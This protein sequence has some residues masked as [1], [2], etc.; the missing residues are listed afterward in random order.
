MSKYK[1]KYKMNIRLHLLAV[2]YT[3]TRDEYSH[4]AFT[5]KVQRFSP[6]MRSRGFEVYHYGVETAQSGA[7]VDIEVL[8]LHEWTELRID[9]MMFLN[10]QMSRIEATNRLNDPT[11]LNNVIFNWD[12]PLCKTFNNR[13][14]EK[15][16]NNYR[17]TGTDIVCI[18][19]A[20][21]HNIAIKD[22]N[23]VVVEY[24]IGYAGS[25]KNFRVFESNGW[26]SR[27][28]G[29]ENKNPQNYWFICSNFYNID[30][31]KFNAN[32]TPNRVGF[33]GRI[34]DVKG[35][36]IIVEIA[37]RF[38]HVQF[39]L[40][41]Q[42]DPSK[43]LCEKNI[44]YQPPIHG[45]QRSEYLASLIAVIA[46]SKFLEPFC[47]VAVEA[48]LCGTPVIA[49]D[50]GGFI[51]NIEQFKCGLRCHTLADYCYAVQMALDGKFNR[52][53]IRDHAVQMFDMYNVA[54][55]Y[56]YIFKSIMDITNGKN[57]W[58]SKDSYIDSLKNFY[59]KE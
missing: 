14:R 43:Y 10:P 9:S 48:Q 7:N 36:S 19:L 53:Y 34:E 13:L 22:N 32:P 50:W 27:T 54:H 8:S 49:S 39:V 41:G 12:T 56:E 28:L 55:N 25:N 18:P 29:T 52:Q 35:C 20:N 6:M 26:M 11:F 58:Y 42:G 57:G 17:G 59:I 5:G 33:L 15:L 44:V 24:S 31:W 30:D 40:C 37:R 16:K 4:C 21:S 2:P 38:P 51:D 45:V 23:Y 3:I 46:P 1:I 47:S